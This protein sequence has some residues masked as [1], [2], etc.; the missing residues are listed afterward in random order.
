LKARGAITNRAGCLN[1]SKHYV[2]WAGADHAK[3]RK[4]RQDNAHISDLCAAF[5]GRSREAIKYRIE[6]LKLQKPRRE[7]KSTGYAIIDSIRQRA[8]YLN[9]SMRELD[10]GCR[11]KNYFRRS[12]WRSGLSPNA[13]AAA[14]RV[15]GGRLSIE[16][17]D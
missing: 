9:M 14:A 13:V 1:V 7:F 5:P 12:V 3:L 15:L 16:W 10:A 8:R 6:L 11:S 4:M 2:P 17:D